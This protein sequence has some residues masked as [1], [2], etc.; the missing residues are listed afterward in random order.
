MILQ[1]HQRKWWHT[2]RTFKMYTLHLLPGIHFTNTAI[3]LRYIFDENPVLLIPLPKSS[4]L[5]CQGPQKQGSG[6]EWLRGYKSFF[7][8]FQIYAE[9]YLNFQ[10][11]KIPQLSNSCYYTACNFTKYKAHLTYLSRWPPIRYSF[12]GRNMRV[13]GSYRI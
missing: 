9:F 13:T 6:Q 7:S 8:L 3:R 10:A 1:S 2:K 5:A 12:Q 4:H 11:L